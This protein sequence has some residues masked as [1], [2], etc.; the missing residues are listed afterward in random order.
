MIRHQSELLN[1]SIALLATKDPL[2]FQQ[3]E[4]MRQTYS[5]DSDEEQDPSDLGEYRRWIS[6]HGN[7]QT[8]EDLNAI[9]D[10][11]LLND[12]AGLTRAERQA[13]LG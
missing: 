12:V 6:E 7:I 4:A 8:F 9:S 2:A 13:G 3:V 10:A 5:Q 11:G 1:R